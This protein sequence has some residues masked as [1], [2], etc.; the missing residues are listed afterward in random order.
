MTRVTLKTTL[1]QSFYLRVSSSGIWRRVVRWVSTDVSEEL[2]ASIFRVEED[3]TAS[4]PRRWYSSKLPLWKPQIL[5]FFYCCVCIRY[6]GNL[7]TELLPNNYRG[8]FTEQLPS[9]DKRMFTEPLPI[10]DRG[11]TQTHTHTQT[12]MWSHKPTLSFQ[13]KESRLK[14][15]TFP[16]GWQAL[17]MGKRFFLST[18]ITAIALGQQRLLLAGSVHLFF[19]LPTSVV[20]AG[21]RLFTNF[22]TFVN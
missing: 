13:N 8:M 6:R 18:L 14:I 19:S 20:S 9:N 5:Q 21:P 10:N 22:H 1:Q 7:S 16:T 17:A 12:A 3:Y 11:D 2:I 15:Y 4:Y